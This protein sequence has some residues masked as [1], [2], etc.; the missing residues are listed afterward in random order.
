MILP[1]GRD[2]RPGKVLCIG[3]NYVAHV[4]E[5]GGRE[6]DQPVV[7]LK[8]S[9]ALIAVVTAI[10]APT[11]IVAIVTFVTIAMFAMFARVAMTMAPG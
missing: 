9:S 10:E 3:R 5:M 1:D 2:L 8:P 11:T 6:G 7:F 4:I